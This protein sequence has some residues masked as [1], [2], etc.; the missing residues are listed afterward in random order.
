M[1][2]Q[3]GGTG[4]W[5]EGDPQLRQLAL[6]AVLTLGWIF[7]GDSDDHLLDFVAG[8]RFA[9]FGL[10]SASAYAIGEWCRPW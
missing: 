5:A 6:D 9:G 10:S 8:R 2:I 7:I 3:V 4:R 1:A